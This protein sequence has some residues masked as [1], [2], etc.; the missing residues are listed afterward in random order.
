LLVGRDEE[1][2]AVPMYTEKTDILTSVLHEIGSNC[3]HH[4]R[5]IS[6]GG[7]HM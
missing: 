7:V 5:K 6:L 4:W 3:A 1:S 2:P